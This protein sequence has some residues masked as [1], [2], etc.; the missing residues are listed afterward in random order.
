M[1]L[2]VACLVVTEVTPLESPI[3]VAHRCVAL[4]LFFGIR[5]S[6][7]LS[8]DS[9]SSALGSSRLIFPEAMVA[10]FCWELLQT[11]SIREE[12]I[13]TDMDEGI[14]LCGPSSRT[15]QGW[16]VL[17]LSLWAW[18]KVVRPRKASIGSMRATVE[19]N[20][21][22]HILRIRRFLFR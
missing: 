18:P 11:D 22:A 17:S 1:A 20:Q 9:I 2:P 12:A 6:S 13:D 14:V 16:K 5:G 21:Y 4:H 3:V 15:A 19:Y 8:C 10:T 7:V